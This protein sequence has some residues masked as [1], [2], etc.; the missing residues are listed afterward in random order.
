MMQPGQVE[1]LSAD[2]RRVIAPNPSAM[3]HAGTNSYLVGRG[4]DVVLIDPGPNAPAHVQAILTALEPK[5]SLGAI[6]V[7][8]AHSDHSAAVP[9]WRQARAVPV[10]AYGPAIRGRSPTMQRLI[11]A[12][13]KSGGEGIDHAFS[14]DHILED[15]AVLPCPGGDLRVIHTPGHIGNHICLARGDV[16]FSGDHAMGWSSSL[17]SPPDGDMGAYIRSLKRLRQEDWR[18]LLPGHGE[19]VENGSARLKELLA[20]RLQREDQVLRALQAAPA[21]A[22]A[23]TR[24]IYREISVDLHPAAQRNVFAHLIDLVER[25]CVSCPDLAASETIFTFRNFPA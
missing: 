15:G 17:V 5:E 9:L 6:V 4:A 8:H 25:S 19:V 13:L 14:P 23:L 16:L 24:E 2:I 1:W 20:H 7:T 3:T 12:G 11:E 18:L 22:I 21:T 10:F